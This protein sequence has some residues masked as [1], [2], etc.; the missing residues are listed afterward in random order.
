LGEFLTKLRFRENIRLIAV[1]KRQVSELLAIPPQFGSRPN[2]AG[3]DTDAA[4]RAASRN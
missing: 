3:N 1:G 2:V 4:A